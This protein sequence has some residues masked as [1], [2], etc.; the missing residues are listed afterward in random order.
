[1]LSTV[2]IPLDGRRELSEARIIFALDDASDICD[3]DLNMGAYYWIRTTL[4]VMSLGE[5]ICESPRS[6]LAVKAEEVV[7]LLNTR[8]NSNDDGS[9]VAR[10]CESLGQ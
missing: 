5:N 7:P 2:R 6:M 9:V 10:N 8:F 3:I 1:M 4:S